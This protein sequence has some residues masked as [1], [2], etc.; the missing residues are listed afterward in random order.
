MVLCHE[1]KE[2]SDSLT[3]LLFSIAIQHLVSSNNKLPIVDF[4]LFRKN[5][6]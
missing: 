2:D 6:T 1:K 3:C 4:H 5:G